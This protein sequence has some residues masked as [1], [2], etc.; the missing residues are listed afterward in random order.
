[1][2]IWNLAGL[3]GAMFLLAITP[4]PGVF[5]TTAR[6]LASGFAHASVVVAGI[7]VGDLLFLLLAIYGL[8][9]IATVLGDLFAVVKIA[10]GSYLVWLGIRVW[11]SP[12][13]QLHDTPVR[14]LS[15][16]ATFMSGLVI[17]L[18]NPKVILFYLG[19]LPTFIDLTQMSLASVAMVA[20]VVSA[21]LG[22]VLL[23]YAVL[24]ARARTFF[25]GQRA[26]RNMNRSAGAVMITTGAILIAKN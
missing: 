23:G 12:P 26:Q 7:V 6:A 14:A 21:V 8:S 5:A 25:Q 22:G 10:G 24:A 15:W 17:T 3:A 1:M 13:R 19:F 20:I 9:A 16:K 4:G 11:R 2:T 18:G